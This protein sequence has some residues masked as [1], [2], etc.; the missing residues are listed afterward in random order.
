MKTVKPY[1]P[2]Q[3]RNGILEGVAALTVVGTIAVFLLTTITL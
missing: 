1:S 2:K 3:V